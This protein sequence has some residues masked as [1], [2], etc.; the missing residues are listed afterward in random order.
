MDKTEF[1]AELRR[2]GFR[3]VERETRDLD[4]AFLLTRDGPQSQQTDDRRSDQE[5]AKHS[6]QPYSQA[7]PF[8]RE[9]KGKRQKGK[10][11]GLF[12]F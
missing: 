7:M 6:C 9:E 1:E 5:G 2:D 4:A 12:P 10:G 8:V 11:E 3:P